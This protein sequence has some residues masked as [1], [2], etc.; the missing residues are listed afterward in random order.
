VLR[1]HSVIASFYCLTSCRVLGHTD[2]Q[3][4]FLLISKSVYAKIAYNIIPIKS[5]LS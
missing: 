5:L 1:S 2:I 4:D 3:E